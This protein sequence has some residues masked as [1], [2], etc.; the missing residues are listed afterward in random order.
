MTQRCPTNRS[1]NWNRRIRREPFFSRNVRSNSQAYDW[2]DRIDYER[3]IKG[4]GIDHPAWSDP[5]RTNEKMSIYKDFT[6]SDLDINVP[7]NKINE[8]SAEYPV[9]S[10]ET[11]F[12]PLPARPDKI[13][14][15]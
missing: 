14:Q 9:C 3:R 4:N 7:R 8:S 13:S 6:G 1:S 15:E 10:A 11:E 12:C 2:A 5:F